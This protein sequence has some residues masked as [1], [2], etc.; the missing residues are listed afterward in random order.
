MFAHVSPAQMPPG[1]P[2]TKFVFSGELR[3]LLQMAESVADPRPSG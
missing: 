1:L 3:H 2:D